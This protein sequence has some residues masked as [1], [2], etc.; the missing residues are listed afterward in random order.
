MGPMQVPAAAPKD[1]GAL[2]AGTAEMEQQQEQQRWS[3]R[4]SGTLEAATVAAPAA[5]VAAE[6]GWHAPL[7]SSFKCSMAAGKYE[8]RN[9][10]APGRPHW[11]SRA[12]LA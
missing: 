7:V 5:M 1:S 9:S 4:S 12:S 3:S 8:P 11:D 6:R 10:L 2:A